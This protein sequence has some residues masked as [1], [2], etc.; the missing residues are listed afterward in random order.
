MHF[1]APVAILAIA[2]GV[3]A[4]SNKQAEPPIHKKEGS[5]SAAATGVQTGTHPIQTGNVHSSNNGTVV[6][7]TAASSTVP[8]THPT[9]SGNV[10]GGGG[11]V[12]GGSGSSSGSSSGSGAGSSGAGHTPASPSSTGFTPSNPG[13]KVS[14]PMAGAAL[15]SVAYGLALLA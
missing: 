14:V 9:S 3:Q 4:T 6:T 13:A 2:A 12:G 7:S 5:I 10:V 1:S 15:G 11:N 8:A